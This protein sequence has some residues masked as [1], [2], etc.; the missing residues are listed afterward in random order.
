MIDHDESLANDP[1]ATLVR[2]SAPERF[3]SGFSDR[4]AA[5]LRADREPALSTVLQRQFFQI[6]PIVAAASLMLAAYNWWGARETSSS[7]IEAV[8]NLP[9]VTLASAY[10]SSV[11]YGAAAA[12]METQ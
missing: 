1:L 12:D 10:S 4:V 8:L 6:V 3:E 9:Q 5:R 2:A 11:L 7:P